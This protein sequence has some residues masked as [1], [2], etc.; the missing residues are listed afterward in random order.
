MRCF[1]AVDLPEG[2][3]AEFRRI[4]TVLK[5][6]GIKASFTRNYHLTL[7]FLGELS[8]QKAGILF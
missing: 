8:Q 5:D 2:I 7:K 3:S 1:V 6:C 4:Q